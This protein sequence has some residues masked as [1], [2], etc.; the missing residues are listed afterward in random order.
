MASEAE[1]QN[2]LA[3]EPGNPIFADYIALLIAHE[4]LGEA[5]L[6]G[7]R[8][9]SNNPECYKGRLL[10]AH[11]MFRSAYVP[12]AVREVQ[13]LCEKFPQHMHLK[14]LL[15]RLA[16]SLTTASTVK[17]VGQIEEV[18]DVEF[19]IDDLDKLGGK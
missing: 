1:M 4:K 12:F 13:I 18:A 7:M 10:L 9:L 14:S 15:E 19:D 16:P 17:N 6:V 11:A 8:G 5:I 3:Q 2:I